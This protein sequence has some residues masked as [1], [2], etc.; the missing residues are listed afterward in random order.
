MPPGLQVVSVTPDFCTVDGNTVVCPGPR[1]ISPGE[2]F[3]LTIVAT[4]TECGD[5]VNTAT[6]VLF[7]VQAPFTVV[8]C[9][10]A[11]GGGEAAAPA[12][13]TQESEQESESGEIDQSFDIS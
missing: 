8:G 6:D 13:I 10:E 2:A 9:E 1:F 5:V 4:P 12:E 7:T 11:G 3:T